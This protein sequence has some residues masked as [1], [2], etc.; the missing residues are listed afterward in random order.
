MNLLC[1]TLTTMYPATIRT[2]H[3]TISGNQMDRNIVKHNNTRF[4]RRVGPILIF[5]LDVMGIHWR[6]EPRS[7]KPAG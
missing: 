1:I 6:A 5:Q 2:M 4:D 7:D 3:D